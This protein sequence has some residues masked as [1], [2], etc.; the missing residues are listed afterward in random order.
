M[1]RTEKYVKGFITAGILFGLIAALPL[2][3][4]FGLKLG[5]TIT[6]L[7][8][9]IWTVLMAI[10]FIPVDYLLTKNLPP[11]ALN[12]RQERYLLIRGNFDQVFEKCLSVLKK[13]RN[14]R[15][16]EL[17]KDKRMILARTKPSIAS[18]GERITLKFDE[19]DGNLVKVIINSYPLTRYNL[20][21]FGRNFKN[22]EKIAER[23]TSH[24]NK[25]V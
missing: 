4:K 21:D 23:I 9:A 13:V 7:A 11:E 14:L 17:L 22:V 25:Q 8:S 6:I 2:T 18:F 10:I 16:L 12:V 19:T 15:K 1:K 5:I 24:P 20:L 3:L